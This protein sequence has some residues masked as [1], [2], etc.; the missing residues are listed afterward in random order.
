MEDSAFSF[1]AED[2]A[3]SPGARAAAMP[4]TAQ[5]MGEMMQMEKVKQPWAR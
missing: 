4:I 5:A 3:F 1:P 2:F